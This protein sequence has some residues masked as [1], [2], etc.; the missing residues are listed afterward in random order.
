VLHIL[1]QGTGK[2]NPFFGTLDQAIRRISKDKDVALEKPQMEKH[3]EQEAKTKKK[4]TMNKELK[5]SA[6]ATKKA[7]MKKSNT[8]VESSLS[9]DSEILLAPS[10]EAFY[11]LLEVAPKTNQ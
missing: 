3:K 6:K 7:I 11:T 10:T 2:D 8:I 4:L 5:A 9:F 1:R